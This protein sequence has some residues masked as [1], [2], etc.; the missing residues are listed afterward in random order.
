MERA[1]YGQMS[2][3]RCI[4]VDLGYMG[5]GVD[6]LYIFDEY[7]TGKRQ[8]RILVGDKDMAARSTCPKGLLHYLEASYICRKGNWFI[9]EYNWVNFCIPS[10]TCSKCNKCERTLIMLSNL[11]SPECFYTLIFQPCNHFLYT[12][13]VK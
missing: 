3:G 11:K 6:V 2:I 12:I 8:C 13:K 10:R 4:E 1:Q 9:T 7:C 5:C